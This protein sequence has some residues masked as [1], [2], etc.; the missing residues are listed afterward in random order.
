MSTTMQSVG[1][2][3]WPAERVFYLTMA[4]AIFATVFV[5][6][7]RSFFLRPLFP[8]WPSPAEPVFYI[9]GAVFTS[10]YVLFVVQSWLVATDRR[11]QHRRLG[12]LG[13]V[14]AVLMVALGS[15]AALIAAS[16]P[17][18]FIGVPVPPLSFLVIPLFDMALFATLVGLA[19]VERAVAQTHKRLMLL[20][21]ISLLV[22][23]VARWPVIHDT[24]IL[25]FFGVADLFLVPLVVWDLASRGR[26]HTV[27]LVGVLTL[28]ISQPLRLVVSGTTGWLAFANWATGLVR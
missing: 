5:G 8:R 16:R 13:A 21:S 17:G 11:P 2:V 20:A 23:A 4:V 28:L 3:R 9:H 14:I 27:T 10:W 26:V 24:G 7:A 15:Y 18:G 12:V 6:F 25:V 22:A 1:R 19:I